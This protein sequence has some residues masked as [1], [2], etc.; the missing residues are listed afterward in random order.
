MSIFIAIVSVR[1]Q[2]QENGLVYFVGQ[3]CI[4]V[5]L[6]LWMWLI[7]TLKV[8]GEFRWKELSAVLYT[9]YSVLKK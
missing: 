7:L 8:Q 4:V 1:V 3:Q 5:I 2:E 9:L 6:V